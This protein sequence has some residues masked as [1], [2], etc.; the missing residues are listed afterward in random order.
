MIDKP[1][2][3]EIED[4]LV[5]RW[6]GQI[7]ADGADLW[8]C[9]PHDTDTEMLLLQSIFESEARGA[10]QVLEKPFLLHSFIAR[11]CEIR[12]QESDELVQGVRLMLL[13]QGDMPIATTSW[14][15]FKS[16]KG[17][18]KDLKRQPPWDPPIRVKITSS[19]YRGMPYFKLV[20]VVDK[21]S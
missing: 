2:E 14:G 18:V 4:G 12:R 6:G 5:V 16:V 17:L 13:V 21:E 20:P 7:G 19:S 9:L 3:T 1:L 15:V 11:P 10:R 8:T